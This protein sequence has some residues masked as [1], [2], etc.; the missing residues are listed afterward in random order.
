[1]RLTVRR[2]PT[3]VRITYDHAGLTHF[4]GV[5]LFHEFLRML[6]FRDF[7]AQQIRYPR[8]NRDYSVSQ[9][10][11]ALV[12]PIILGL[13]RIETASLLRYNGTFQYLTGLPNFPDPQTLRRF[14]LGASVQFADQLRSLNDRL[15][16]FFTHQPHC[17]SRLILDLDST[18]LTLF[19]H[20]EGATLGY[21]P[22][23]RGKRS[24]Q[25]LFCVEAG[26][27]H[28]W[29]TRLRPGR[30]DPQ[31]GIIDLFHNC[32]SNLPTEIRAVRV[33]TDAGFYHGDFLTELED[34]AV[35]YSVVA[36]IYPPLQRLLPGLRYQRVNDT[37]EMADCEYRAFTWT[38]ARRHVVA[39]RLVDE[40]SP[41]TLF[42]LGHYQYRCWVTNLGLSPTGI[43]HFSDGR[44]AIEARIRE[45]RQSF[46][47][48]HIPT[49]VFAANA[50]YLEIIRF[51]YNL[52]IAFQRLCLPSDWQAFTLQT[53][54]RKLFLLPGELTYPQNRPV[55]RLSG[56]P[57]VERLSGHI[58]GSI[59]G[60]PSL[61]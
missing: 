24:Y 25:P 21:H 3:S 4:G 1:M 37:W 28:L 35:Q 56:T 6:H 39:R 29:G 57:Q 38:E 47:L 46:A 42:S 53:L 15:L 7:I 61:P 55:L 40:E 20:Q 33:R 27:A 2:S 30:T 8:R 5:H 22:R 41:G 16:Q 45:L 32:W 59:R 52:V 43:W 19:G 34:S 49:R 9:I 51:A 44:A 50:L 17:R 12:Y 26:S 48:A 36:K 23:H 11:V 14:L 10:L 18:V 31:A 60:L 58:L 54:R 13:D